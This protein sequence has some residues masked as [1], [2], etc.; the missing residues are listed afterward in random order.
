MVFV[1]AQVCLKLV[2]STSATSLAP[3]GIGGGLP[4]PITCTHPHQYCSGCCNRGN[5]HSPHVPCSP[6]VPPLLILP[7]ILPSILLW[8]L[9]PWELCFPLPSLWWICD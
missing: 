9:Q 3:S 7:S 1:M 4:R 2:N 6:P 5:C 8:R